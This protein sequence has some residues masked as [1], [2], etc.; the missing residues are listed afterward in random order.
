[1][2]VKADKP[3]ETSAEAQ[4]ELGIS[5][6]RRA[7]WREAIEPLQRAV[8]LEPSLVAAHYQLGEAF[9]ATDQLPLALESY[10][11]AA[12]LQPDH[13]RALKGIGVVLDRMGKPVEATAA[14][15]RAREVQRR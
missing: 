3:D 10:E 8:T 2:T 12:K 14:Y 13:W 9:N 15:Q 1:M 7:R 6:A 4:L 11:A 5:L